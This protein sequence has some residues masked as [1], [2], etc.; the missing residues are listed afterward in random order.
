MGSL[1]RKQNKKI[2]LIL[3]ALLLFTGAILLAGILFSIWFFFPIKDVQPYSLLPPDTAAYFTINFDSKRP[4]IIALKSRAKEFLLQSNISSFQKTLAGFAFSSFFPGQVSGIIAV[5]KDSNTPQIA[6]FAGFDN[7]VKLIKLFSGFIDKVL[8]RGMPVIKQKEQGHSYKTIQNTGESAQQQ[9]PITAY[10]FISN[11]ICLGTDTAL[12]K[13]IVR[14]YKQGYSAFPG[15]KAMA[16][17][18]A[19]DKEEK[20]GYFFMDNSHGHLSGM[21]SLVEEKFTFAAFPSID[22]IEQIVGYLWLSEEELSGTA[23]FVCND[24]GALEDVRGDVKFFYQA[25][26]RLLKP[27]N[28]SLKGEITIDHTMVVF[29]F[30]IEN[31]LEDIFQQIK[32]NQGGGE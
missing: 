18:I 4:G 22:S 31:F 2:P 20:D 19:D 13:N 5:D 29:H 27:W 9:L 10:T 8:F 14:S 6:G 21:I 28:L 1:K 24:T 26:R 12:V 11:T 3:K 30:T 7:E 15:L 17:I 23:R 25:L 16:G 32:E